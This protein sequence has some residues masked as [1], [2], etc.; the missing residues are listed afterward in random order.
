MNGHSFNGGPNNPDEVVKPIDRGLLEQAKAKIEVAREAARR[1]EAL[2]AGGAVDQERGTP[3]TSSITTPPGPVNRNRL[4][5]AKPS[6]D[7]FNPSDDTRP[8]VRPVLGPDGNVLYW[9]QVEGDED[10]L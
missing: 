7:Q 2:R 1:R 4:P 5:P 3:P 10:G 9:E 8:E 6:E